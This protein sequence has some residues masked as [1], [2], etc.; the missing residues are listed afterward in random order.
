MITDEQLAELVR[1]QVEEMDRQNEACSQNNKYSQRLK[2][3]TERLK[4]ANGIRQY[5]KVYQ[6]TECNAFACPDG[7][8]RVFS[9]LIDIL[10]DNELLG[11][12]GHEIGHVAL[13][14]SKKAWQDALLRSAA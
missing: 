10:D 2:C 3:L 12:I 6:T 14:H 4:D 1:S 9:A 8:V 5:F 13:R 7:S 11:V